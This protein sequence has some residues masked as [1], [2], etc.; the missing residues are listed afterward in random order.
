VKVQ[1]GGA[2]AGG[3]NANDGKEVLTRLCPH[4][5]NRQTLKTL[6]RICP[7]SRMDQ[8]PDFHP[9]DKGVS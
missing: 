3:T 7:H 1:P 9:E 8:F 6:P 2:L 5:E 4:L